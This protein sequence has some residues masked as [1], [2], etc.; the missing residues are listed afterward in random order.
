[1]ILKIMIKHNKQG[2]NKPIYLD[3]E[4]MGVKIHKISEKFLP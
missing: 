2:C 1:M 3:P 4:D